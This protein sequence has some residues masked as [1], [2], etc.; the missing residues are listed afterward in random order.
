MTKY[1]YDKTPWI[2][3]EGVCV[4]GWNEVV[5]TLNEVAP[6]D[7]KDRKIVVVECYPG[8]LHEELSGNLQGINHDLFIDTRTLMLSEDEIRD[9]TWPDV[10]DDTIFGYLTRLRLEQYF[11]EDAIEQARA[12]I[13]ACKGNVIVYGTG[14]ALV[15]PESDCLV[16]ADM[17]RWE[18][19]ARQRLGLVNGVGVKDSDEAPGIQYKRGYFVDWRVCDHHKK[20]LFDKADFWLD[21]NKANNPKMIAGSVHLHA[22]RNAVKQPFRV[23]PFFDPGPWGGQWMKEVCDLDRSKTNFAWCFDCVPEENSLLIHVDGKIVEIPSINLVF[24]QSKELL[25]EPVESRFGQEFPIRFDFLDTMKGGNLSLQVHPTTQYIRDQF[26]MYYTQDESYYILDADKNAT[27]YLGV[28]NGVDPKEMIAALQEAQK[29]EAPFDTDRFIN[30]FP[31]KKHDHFLIPNGTIHCS[32]ADSMVL[33]ISA[34]PYIFTFKL[35]DWNRLGLDG[36]PRPINIKHG[37]NVIQWNRDTDYC[38][39]QLVNQV[40]PIAQGEGWREER[41]G[42]HENEF[43]ETRRHWFT[44]AVTHHTGGGVNV[45][46]LVEGDEAIVESP[47]GAFDPFVVHYAE[48]FIIPAQLGEYTIKPYGQS[49]GKECATIKAYVRFRD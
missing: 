11:S 1:L 8:V 26:G 17:A 36:K 5:S 47:T 7:G 18:I 29:G 48:T 34:T 39:S 16:Y 28:K 45:L 41:T 22:L 32:G 43:I 46:N 12:M 24:Y 40:T 6:N 13:D 35:W 31:A 3:V 25:G 4:E 30:Q 42:L 37:A 20:S 44:D 49:E 27:V 14:A 10:T 23:V 33:E 38:Q 2:E 19:Q 9:L 21:T 15:C